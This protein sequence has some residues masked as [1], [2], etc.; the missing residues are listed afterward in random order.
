[1]KAIGYYKNLSADDPSAL[2]DLELPAPVATGHDLLVEV[3][4]V[5]VNPVDTKLRRNRA[6]A[7]G[8]ADVLGYDAAGIVRAVGDKA[9]LFKV[10]DAVFYA[11]DF[12]R[13]GS[14][15][16]LQLVDE[17]IVGRK[18]ATLDFA[19]AAALP[20]TAITA[21]ELLFDRM[22]LPRNQPARNGDAP[23]PQENLLIVGGAG[24][25]GSI[26]IQLARLLTPL[27]VIAT[28]SRPE[29]AAWCRDLGAHLVIDHTKPLAEELRRNGIES[30]NCIA[31]LTNT[32]QYFTSYVD[33]IAPQGKL[34]VID[35]LQD[36][37]DVRLLKAKC[38]SFHWEFMFVRPAFKTHDILAQHDI[39]TQV[40]DL[41]DAGELRSTHGKTLGK[42]NAENLRH[43]HQL[44]ESGH[45]IG[46]IVLENFV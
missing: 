11:G 41:I 6:P 33:I 36:P 32:N 17:R 31:S 40:A 45:T 37:I 9:S 19:S 43:A 13:P 29:S 26:M 39:L 15:A 28:A 12:T 25:V 42:I 24:G 23:R 22:Q 18:P 44:Q 2:V 1:M 38:A 3:R 16:E 30:V 8:K 35:D 46:K 21:W 10:G 7:D 27:N 34:G 5:A 4:A 14:N 20:L